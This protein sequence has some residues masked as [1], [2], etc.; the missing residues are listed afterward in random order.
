MSFY[1]D[2]WLREA[3]DRV[4]SD[5]TQAPEP[6]GLGPAEFDRL[7]DAVEKAIKAALIE[8]HGSIP[9]Q[10]SHKQLVALCEATG[11]WDILP[12]ALKNLVQ[13]VESYRSSTASS[14]GS[15]GAISSPEQ[16]QS[17][18]SVARRLIDY[19]EYHVI[20]NDSVLK[21]LKVA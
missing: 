7:A 17:Y 10:H 8:N 2:P 5:L 21:R 11:V 9:Q 6:H 12:P 1:A 19:M 18:F 4:N 14:Q 20:G 15:V 16:M 13:E 3:R